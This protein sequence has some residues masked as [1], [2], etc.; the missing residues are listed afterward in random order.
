MLREQMNTSD[1]HEWI[2]EWYVFEEVKPATKYKV[3]IECEDGKTTTAKLLVNG[4]EI[5]QAKS[6]CNPDDKFKVAIGAK[7]ALD[8]LFQKK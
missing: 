7:I 1:A 3:F 2:S 8:R 4:S 5:K 6:L